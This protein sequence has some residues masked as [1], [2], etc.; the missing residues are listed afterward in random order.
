MLRTNSIDI[1]L[2]HIILYWYRCFISFTIYYK[3]VSINIHIC[4]Y[5]FF[6]VCLSNCEIMAFS[7]ITFFAFMLQL[8][9]PILHRQ[10]YFHIHFNLYAYEKHARTDIPFDRLT[11]S[12]TNIIMSVNSS[13]KN[14]RSS[15][16]VLSTK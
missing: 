9:L 7:I 12:C 4:Y 16:L 10:M 13:K 6:Y 14:D 8:Y 11:L 15:V 5:E 3:S 2:F 1:T